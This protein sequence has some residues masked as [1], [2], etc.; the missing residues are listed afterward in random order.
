MTCLTTRTTPRNGGT[1]TWVDR[2]L[3][4]YE[5]RTACPMR[6]DPA[7]RPESPCIRPHSGRTTIPPARLAGPGYD[8][9]SVT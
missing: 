5:A 2:Q 4:P 3:A 1:Q 6:R 8:P 7:L 9:N